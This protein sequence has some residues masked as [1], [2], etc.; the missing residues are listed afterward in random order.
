[1]NT[2]I[3]VAAGSGKRFGGDIPKQFLKILGK[4]LINYTL[5]RF[6]S[7][8]SVDELILVISESEIENISNYV[9][10]SEFVKLRKILPGGNSRAE[11]VFKGFN[12]IEQRSANIIAVH[13]GA[14]PLVTPSEIDLT[15]KKAEEIGAACLVGKVTDTIKE[16]AHGNIKCTLDRSKLRSALTPQCFRYEILRRAFEEYRANESV[17]DESSMVEKT[18]VEVALV[19]GSGTNFKVTTKEDLLVA[20]TFLRVEKDRDV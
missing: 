8:D 15:V 16:V 5:E 13:D 1:M 17:T 6:E 18:G 2:A 3:I 10:Q 12:A 19:E 9:N 4:P 11:S 20:E 7:C 14:R